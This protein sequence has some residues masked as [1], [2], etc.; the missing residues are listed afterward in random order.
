MPSNCP[1]SSNIRTPI[2]KI[3][4]CPECESEIEIFSNEMTTECSNCGFTVYNDT[5]SCIRWCSHA[6][7]C[8]GEEL[9]AEVTRGNQPID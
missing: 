2:L 3:R 9:F 7:E 6:K 8:V 1:G 5:V 4:L